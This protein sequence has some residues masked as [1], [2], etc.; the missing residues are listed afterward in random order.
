MDLTLPEAQYKNN[1]GEFF[2]ALLDKKI[3][4]GIKT[5]PNP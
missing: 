2:L 5:S 3:N 4:H 1:R